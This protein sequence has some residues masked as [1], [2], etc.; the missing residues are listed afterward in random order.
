MHLSLGCTR[1]LF[2]SEH[3]DSFCV[4]VCICSGE[5]ASIRPGIIELG[6]PAIAESVDF[7]KPGSSGLMHPVIYVPGYA[8][9]CC[10]T[11]QNTPVVTPLSAPVF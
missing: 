4:S 1:T 8:D 3:S 9:T 2:L 5:R 11:A 6:Y 10:T 7:K